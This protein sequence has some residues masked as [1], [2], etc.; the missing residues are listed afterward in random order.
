MLRSYNITKDS[1]GVYSAL[2][3]LISSISCQYSFSN[4]LTASFAFPKF[5]FPFQVSDLAVNPFHYTKYLFFS[6][7]HHLFR[8][9]STSH[10]SSPSITTGVGCSLF[11]L[12]TWPTYCCILLTLTTK[13]IL[14]I[15]GSSNSTVFGDTILLIL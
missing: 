4:S 7:I 13:C 11:C 6:L 1:S 5:S 8:I 15:A 9:F 10:F 2:V 3:T 12:S 14:I